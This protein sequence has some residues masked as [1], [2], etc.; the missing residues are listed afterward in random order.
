M[1][2]Y[3][4]TIVRR[5]LEFI[6]VGCLAAAQHAGAFTFSDGTSVTCV[7][8]GETVPEYAPPPGTEA[9]TFTGKT[10][11]VGSGYQIVWNAPKLA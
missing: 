3:L 5:S 11:K 9:M 4:T 7:A 2:A 1:P 8:R 10:V 6:A